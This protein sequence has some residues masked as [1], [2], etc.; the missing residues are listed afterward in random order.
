MR[1]RAEEDQALLSEAQRALSSGDAGAVE[2]L[3]RIA[4]T[5]EPE[6]DAWVFA[7]RQL[8]ELAAPED[9]WRAAVLAR[10][11]VR[12]RPDDAHGW[13][14]LA[15]ACSLL[16]HTRA[17]IAAYETALSRQPN[18]PYY[19]HNLGHLYDVGLDRLDDA[20]RWLARA[21]ALAPDDP[22]IA[23]SYAHALARAG[24]L[25]EARRII[26]H[27]ARGGLAPHHE[28]LRRWIEEGA[29]AEAP[30]KRQ[31]RTRT[32]SRS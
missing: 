16:G 27:V 14:L 21:V 4:R 5:A 2:L 31:R 15:L 11:V 6:G 13:A 12:A 25:P 22:E 8:A 9:P 24:R 3:V 18:N 20:V 19:A 7:H 28:P 10:R 30:P 1:R 23:T 17:A 29:G 26:R 32:R